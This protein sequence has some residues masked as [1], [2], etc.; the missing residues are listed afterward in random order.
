MAKK[1]FNYQKLSE[2]SGI[3]IATISR[4]F[5]KSPL[6]TEKMRNSVI[7]GLEELG[8]DPKKYDLV[9]LASEKIIIFNV[10]SI[11]NP[12]YSPIITASREACKRH[13]FSLLILEDP[14]SGS[15]F[16]SFIHLV[17]TINAVGLI[18][19]NSLNKEQAKILKGAI[20]TVC[21]GEANE[22]I[23]IPFVSID[24]RSAAYN[25]VKYLISL[26]RKRIALFNG[27]K[28]TKYASARWRG[29]VEAMKDSALEIDKSLV[30]EL[31]YDMDFELARSYAI[32]ML[33]QKN[34]P[35][36]VFCISDVIASGV[37]NAAHE[38]RIKV[39]EELAIVG[40]DN[41]YIS[42]M[43][44]PSITTINQPTAQIGTMA[45]EMLVKIINGEKDVK[46]IYLGAELIIRESTQAFNH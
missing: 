14:L 15:S 2:V 11:K 17:K 20:P 36:A 3:S 29:F 33:S 30:V 32:N 39:P 7:A 9:P 37:I 21:L 46:S 34:R 23:D 24:D 35:D 45:L 42:Q 31:G 6:V 4:V 38:L 12:F 27:P 10:P 26:N 8:V 44:N 19:A 40:F 22:S 43:M 28:T 1:E 18:V 16:D 41:I 13:G 25:A 5:N